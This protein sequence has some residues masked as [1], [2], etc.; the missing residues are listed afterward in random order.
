[1]ERYFQETVIPPGD[2]KPGGD[3]T[4]PE[5]AFL[6][7]YMGV[8]FEKTMAQK[9]LDRPA[10]VESVTGPMGGEGREEAAFA[11][12]SGEAGAPAGLDEDV[13]ARVR[14]AREIQM[15]IF[16]VA[17]QEF[18]VP[19][20]LVQEVIRSALATKLPAAPYFIAGVMNLRGRVVPLLDMAA[21]LG[22]PSD[23]DGR[24]FTIICRVKG[25]SLGLMVRR[26]STMRRAPA[27]DVEW[28]VEAQ[29]GASADFLD[30]LMKVGERLVKIISV[31][32]LFQKAL[33]S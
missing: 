14:E 29:T 17:D 21:L 24:A 31:D 4:A 23:D 25:L 30:G 20:D 26:I 11:Q 9:G 2:E 22:L 7:K 13:M 8:D 5:R 33:K 18:A 28:G 19:I 32:T 1:M 16:F 12:G 15:V 10:R 3:M 6:E 27:E